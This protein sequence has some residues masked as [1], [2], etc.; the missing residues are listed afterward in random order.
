MTPFQKVA[1]AVTLSVMPIDVSKAA[2]LRWMSG[3]VRGMAIIFRRRR[4]SVKREVVAVMQ[5]RY[6]HVCLH[7]SRI[8][9]L[10]FRA[11]SLAP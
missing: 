7:L 6:M 1:G 9:F 10:V 11:T 3:R 2:L 4:D 5:G 8:E